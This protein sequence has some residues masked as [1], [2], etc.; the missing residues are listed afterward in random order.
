VKSKNP[1]GSPTS[2]ELVAAKVNKILAKHQPAA[3]PE[4]VKAR[5]EGILTEAEARE[6]KV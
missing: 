2:E 4:G 1:K 5:I 3:L 6:K